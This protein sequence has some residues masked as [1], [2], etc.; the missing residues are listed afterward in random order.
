M[1]SPVAIVQVPLAVNCGL[2]FTRANGVTRTGARTLTF[3]S[4]LHARLAFSR[5]WFRSA[6]LSD[7]WS[8]KIKNWT[9]RP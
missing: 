7:T 5:T 6:R 4:R 9:S 2:Q 3:K 8:Y 1:L